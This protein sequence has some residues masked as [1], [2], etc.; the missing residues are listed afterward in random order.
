[1]AAEPVDHTQERITAAKEDIAAERYD[2]AS[3]ALLAIVCGAREVRNKDD[4]ER[5]PS[6]A[7][8][9]TAEAWGLLGELALKNK[10]QLASNDWSAAQ[11]LVVRWGDSKEPGLELAEIALDR[12]VRQSGSVKYAL[13]LATTREKLQKL[14]PAFDAFV[15][16]LES[17]SGAHRQRGDGRRCTVHRDIR[18]ERGRRK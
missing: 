4:L 12:A 2:A 17:S 9:N 5:C 14:G 16:V 3:R 13:S 7:F 15:K 6:P 8:V 10:L 11:R 1:M 18:L